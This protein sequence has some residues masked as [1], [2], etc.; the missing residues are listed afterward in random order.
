MRPLWLAASII[1]IDQVTKA[2]V[3]SRM[4]LGESIPIFGDW[5]KLTFTEN[6]GMAFGIQFGSPAVVTGLAILATIL[7]VLYLRVVNANSVGYTLSLA[8]ILGGAIGNII[9]R[10]L[11][12]VIYGY[13]G[14]FHGQVVDFIHFDVWSG[15]ISQSIPW[16]G[17]N[18]VAVFPIWNVADMSIVVGVV[19]VILFQRTFTTRQ[20]QA[21]DEPEAVGDVSATEPLHS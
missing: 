4:R 16:V 18:Y 8:L 10:I 9:D 14:W 12:A 17:G 5:F 20:D 21:A 6:P 3:R 2:I 15:R 11:F 7:I 19:L 1:S 13:G